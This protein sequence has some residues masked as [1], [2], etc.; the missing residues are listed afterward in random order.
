[1]TDATLIRDALLVNEG[2]SFE[3]DLL[4]RNGR[5]ERIG[6]DLS[7]PDGARVVEARG[8]WLLPG[9]IDDQVHFREPGLTHKGDIH[10]ESRAAVAGGVT[11]FMDMPNTRPTTTDLDALEAKYQAAADRS[12]ANY[13]F[14]LGA[15]NDNIDVIRSLR[16]GQACGVKVFMGAST[17]NML[18]DDERTLEL[19][20]RDAPTV[21]TTHCE[22]TPMIQANLERALAKYGERIPLEEHPRI[23]SAEACMAST[24]VAVG[25][26]REHGT[27]LHVLHLSSA[28]EVALFEPGPV[29]SKSITA[30]VCVHFLHFTEQDYAE[31][32][33]AIKCNPAVKSREDQQGLVQ[34]LIDDR[35]DIIATDHAP[36]TREE[37]ADPSYLKAPAGMPLVQH[38][39]VAALELHFDGTM[40]VARVV[41]KV[42]H[43][44]ALRFGVEERGFLREGA[45]ADLALVDP[46][47]GTEVTRDALL[48][49]CGWSPFEGRRFQARVDATWVNGQLAWD[50]REVIEHGAARRLSFAGRR[51]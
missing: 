6:R 26:A 40:D 28:R 23:R 29:T 24:E 17:G 46:A 15:T 13:A 33:T 51:A 37:K 3:S 22:S 18:V 9:M 20:F 49:R 34:G 35:L 30:E 48:Y 11:S 32:G 27:Q 45:W 21:V 38:V 14:Y 19:I 50:G 12:A 10:S 47:G 36:H 1:M 7:A 16:P 25:L 39:L 5:I 41:E 42:A 44:P 43:N 2:R 4:V 31:R 8:R